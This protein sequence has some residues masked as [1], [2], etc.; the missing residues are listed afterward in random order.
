MLSRDDR[1]KPWRALTLLA[2]AWLPAHLLAQE[3]LLVTDESGVYSLGPVLE[4]LEDPAGQWTI[5]DVRSAAFSNRFERST[6][7]ILN[8]GFTSSAIWTRV[9]VRNLDQQNGR[10]FLE[11][12]YP[13]LDRIELYIV[14]SDGRVDRRVSGDALPFS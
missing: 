3:S 6:S 13:L 11:I 7:E 2:L 8:L 14:T 9:D 10:C 4:I 5:E 1:S 12:V